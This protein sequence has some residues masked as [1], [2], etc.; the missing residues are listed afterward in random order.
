MLVES[1]AQGAVEGRAFVI[2]G[3]AR[4]KAQA[5]GSDRDRGDQGVRLFAGLAGH[6][7]RDEDLVREWSQRREHLAAL[8]DETLPGLFHDAHG[9]LGFDALALVDVRVDQDM[10]Q[11]EVAVARVLPIADGVLT[12]LSVAAPEEV[13][14]RGA[15]GRKRVHVVGEAA[16]HSVAQVGADALAFDAPLDAREIACQ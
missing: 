1:R 14:D 3:L 9:V 2:I 16:H 8:D 15:V 5:L 12:E 7:R 11:G 10:G 6:V 4:E 13:R